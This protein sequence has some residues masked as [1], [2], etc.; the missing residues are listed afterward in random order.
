[1]AA[2][3]DVVDAA[4]VVDVVDWESRRKTK[5]K[6]P[7]RTHEKPQLNRSEEGH[8]KKQLQLSTGR[9]QAGWKLTST[10]QVRTGKLNQTGKP[11]S[12]EQA[13]S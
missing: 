1:M 10:E 2:V 8:C 13:G 12:T 3:A 6:G 4:D 5:R 11:K 7:L 9:I